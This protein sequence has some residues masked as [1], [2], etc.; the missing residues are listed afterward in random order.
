MAIKKVSGEPKARKEPASAPPVELKPAGVVKAQPKAVPAPAARPAPVP[1]A[2]VPKPAA[3]V[4]LRYVGK[5]EYSTPFYAGG[6]LFLVSASSKPFS[7]T[8]KQAARLLKTGQFGV[9][10]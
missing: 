6:K 3:E 1:A 7:A 10:K 4:T 2:P 8:L 9:V 5:L